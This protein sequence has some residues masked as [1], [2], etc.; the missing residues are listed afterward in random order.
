MNVPPQ[1][2]G[3]W[4]PGAV[5]ALALVLATAPAWRVLML[6][7]RPTV[8]ELLRLLCTTRTTGR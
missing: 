1:A 2:G 8:D 3:K 4:L 6:G 7:D 5:F